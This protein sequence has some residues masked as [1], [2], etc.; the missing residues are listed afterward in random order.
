MIY[1]ISIAEHFY[2]EKDENLEKL[3]FSFEQQG[4]YEYM[5]DGD[6]TIEISSL[7][8]LQKFVREY[9]NIVLSEDSI[10][11]YNGYLE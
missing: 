1:K 6:P 2:E 9:G 3:G 10:T 11:I 5:I 8:E 4:S 7:E